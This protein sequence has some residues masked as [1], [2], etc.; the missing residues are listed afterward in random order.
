[1]EQTL[2]SHEQNMLDINRSLFSIQTTIVRTELAS[3][4]Y[5]LGLFEQYLLDNPP[6]NEEGETL[7]PTKRRRIE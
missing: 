6:E 2:H 7:R 3:I 5:R 4:Q 1:M